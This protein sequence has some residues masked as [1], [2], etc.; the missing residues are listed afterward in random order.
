MSISRDTLTQIVERMVGDLTLS[1]NSSQLDISKHVNTLENSYVRGIVEAIAGGIDSNNDLTEQVLQQIF[2][3]TATDEFLER[4]G[5]T[6]GITRQPATKASGTL[7]FTGSVGGIIPTGALLTRSDGEEYLTTSSGSLVSQAIS[8]ASITRIGTTAT[9]TT[10]NNHNF[11]TSQILDSIQ[12]AN[13]NEYNLSNVTISVINNKQFTYQVVGAPTTPATGTIT[14]TEVYTF[15]PVEA[16]DFGSNQNSGS[17]SI[18]TLASPIA[19]VND[20][21]IVT[22]DGIIGGL[23]TESDDDYRVRILERT[24]NFTAPFTKTGIPVFIKQYISGVTRIWINEATPTPGS[25]EIYFTRDDDVNIIPISAQLTE[26]KN[27]IIDGNNLVDGIKP[28]NMSDSSVYVLAPTAV[29]VNFTFSS[30]SPNTEDMQ[31]AIINSLTDFFRSNQIILDQDVLENEYNNAIFNTLDSNGNV[32]IFT[33][34]TP[35]GDVVINSGELATLGIISF[36]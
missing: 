13:Q 12:G 18:L 23:N 1:I 22:F 26:V 35:S 25:T 19:N 34:T 11:G 10:V 17:G 36:P 32:P 15:I 6:F 16:E 31:L 9:V 14:V 7:S 33:L 29:P 24:S 2:I 5:V 20:S 27:L 28:A 3:Q 4:W 8:I 30:L 21:S